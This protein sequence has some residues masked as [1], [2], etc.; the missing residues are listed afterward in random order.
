M[1]SNMRS[2]QFVACLL[3]MF[4]GLGLLYVLLAWGGGR[5]AAPRR[6]RPIANTEEY[7]EAPPAG[8]AAA[9]AGAAPPSP[10]GGYDLQAAIQ[11]SDV[12]LS[13]AQR[14]EFRD[15]RETA[16]QIQGVEERFQA[17][18]RSSEEHGMRPEVMPVPQRRKVLEALVRRPYCG[19]RTRSWRTEFSDS[20]RG[21]VVP[22]N[23]TNTLGMMRL[24]RSDPTKDLHPGALGQMSGREGQWLSDE[25]VPDN[26][27][28]DLD[29]DVL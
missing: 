16:K 25:S 12:T 3:A 2:A 9:P 24:G 26:A 15:V 27:F 28:D 1:A 7:F 14:E 29:E 4:G 20:L 10:D 5:C 6:R 8:A 21:D 23:V 19:R 11:F 13:A 18:K 17:A 22:R